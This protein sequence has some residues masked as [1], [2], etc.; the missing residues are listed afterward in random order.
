MESNNNVSIEN[1]INSMA[2]IPI[3]SKTA[4]VP[5]KYRVHFIMLISCFILWGLLN[6]MTDNLVPAFGRI[7]MLEAADSSLVQVA[8]Y[9]SYAVLAL[10]AAIIIKKYS[11][12]TGV[13]IGLGL[14]IIGAM[15]YIPAAM[16]QNFNLFLIS[17]FVLAG[18]LSI[19]E[20]TCN[21]YVISLGSEETSVR[22]LN[23]AQAF[24][25][26]GSLTGI[27]MAKYL[28]LGNLNPATYEERIAMGADNLKKIQNS[29]LIW[30]CVPYVGL[31]AIALIIWGFFKI[32]KDSEKDN[33]GDLNI[34]SSIKKLVKM[35][36]Y[37][38]G[39]ITQFFYVGVQIA[40]WTWTIKY[41]MVNLGL[42][43]AS[44]AQ[45]YL[46]SIVAFIV[47]R[48]ICTAL[49]K[50]IEP[51]SMMAVFAVFGVLC[52]LGTIFLPTSISV[53]CLVLISACMSLMFPT[54]YGIALEGI[55]DE[56]KVGAA[57][58]IMAILGGAVIT[59]LMG[60]FIDNGKLSAL[61][62]SYQGA[63][64]AVRSS[65]FIPVICFTVILAY[66]LCFRKKKNA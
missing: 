26:I 30:V 25:P 34:I 66:S 12:R 29:E 19:L 53:W 38:F 41:V 17:V 61:A 18:G 37:A 57:G 35:P 49:M 62:V 54:I 3:D 8:F 46:I 28:I 59:P 36:R 9:G 56:V 50:Y 63:E 21:P 14:Y 23:L 58:L 33:S 39:V 20:T 16:L 6:N 55:G 65:F 1:N 64:A 51:A 7:F 52:S 47:C 43:E 48:W 13:L 24:N 60:K 22:R 31:V 11:Y 15:G 27:I 4:I 42:N 2:E 10:P 40:V 32:K 5:K 44:A 45:Y